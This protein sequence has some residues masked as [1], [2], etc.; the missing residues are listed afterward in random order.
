MLQYEHSFTR[1][2][3]IKE[4]QCTLLKYYS[5]SGLE[6]KKNAQSYFRPF[7]INNNP[8]HDRQFS[9]VYV[10]AFNALQ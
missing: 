5:N 4:E 1:L 2:I 10:N 3:F 7:V 8:R 9:Y 6:K